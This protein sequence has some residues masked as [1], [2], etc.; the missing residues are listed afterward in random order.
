M[1]PQ[2]KATLVARSFA[3]VAAALMAT[4]LGA[5]ALAVAV[6]RRV[7]TPPTVREE[8]VRILAVDE[9]G[10]T[11]TL[12][13]TPETVV[14]GRYGMWFDR[15]SGYLRLGTI[16]RV[17]RHSVT[18][19]LESVQCGR[20]AGARTGRW[21]GWYY[22]DPAELGVPHREV[23]IPTPLGPAPAW[24]VPA[25]EDS[26]D[27]LG[28]DDWVIQVHGRGVTRSETLRAVPVF[29]SLGM[30][31]L[32]ISY[33]NDGEAPASADGRYALGDSEWRDVEAAV[34]FARDEGARRLFIMGWSMGA[35]TTL[36][37][38]TR[39]ALRAQVAG[40]ILDSPVVD[41][42][43]VLHA[44][45]DQQGVPDAVRTLALSVLSS[46]WASAWTGRAEPIDFDRLDLVAR[47]AELTTPTLILHSDE[48]TYVPIGGSLALAS[49]RPDIVHLERFTTAR[50][51]RLWNYDSRRW[52]RAI[53]TWVRSLE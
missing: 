12:A 23:S 18:R 19:R 29:R 39:S 1:T 38:V 50:H 44:Q 13:P 53:R 27:L 37:L 17:D 43:R 16:V 15:D 22:R 33:R 40:I 47:A 32:L 36:Q 46:E 42:V 51:T 52:D 41:W 20:L 8:N 9:S 21:S 7:V 25:S 45:A 28:E 10:G 49:A 3:A 35:A 34:Q 48:D 30:T 26:V 2:R 4:G 24:L 6:A 5:L 31:C 14:P 11:I